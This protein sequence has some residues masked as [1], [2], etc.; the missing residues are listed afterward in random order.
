MLNPYIVEKPILRFIGRSVKTE[1]EIGTLFLQMDEIF[2]R[3][4]HPASEIFYGISQNFV[5]GS[6]DSTKTYWLCKEVPTLQ[7]P[8][9][10][11][12]RL[13]AAMEALVLPATR[14]L[15]IPVRYDDPFVRDL[16]P[17]E[18]RE[19]TGYLTVCVFT[20]ARQW[21]RDNGYREQDFPYE[22]EIYGLHEGYG[23]QGANLTLAI[24]IV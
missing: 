13:Q 20:W 5:N 24:P 8:D 7:G 16:A 10:T 9:G 1:A 6:P 21:L 23:D 18:H 15:Y 3:I 4:E 12:T 2:S 17:A 19:D 11:W 14:W 22:L